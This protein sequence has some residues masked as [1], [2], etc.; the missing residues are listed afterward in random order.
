MALVGDPV[1]PIHQAAKDG[2]LEVLRR[3]GKKDLNKQDS[4][5]GWTPVHWCS[6]RGDAEALSIVLSRG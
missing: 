1:H 6:W 4:D 5:D 2:N 3:S